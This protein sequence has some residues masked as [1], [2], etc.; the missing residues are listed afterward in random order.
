MTVAACNSVETLRSELG[1]AKTTVP[2]R[3]ESKAAGTFAA[4]IGR[5]FLVPNDRKKSEQELLREA[6]ERSAAAEFRI[7][8]AAYWRWQNEFLSK[9]NNLDQLALKKMRFRKWRIS[10]KMM[11]GSL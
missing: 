5:Q 8:R 4:V 2:D 9:V 3:H 1:L 10:L 7:K 11:R 6:I